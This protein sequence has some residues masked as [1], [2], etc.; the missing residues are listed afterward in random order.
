M[1]REDRN[2]YV[3]IAK[4]DSLFKD[5]N[6]PLISLDPRRLNGGYWIEETTR[7]NRTKYHQSRKLMFSN[8]KLERANKIITSSIRTDAIAEKSRLIDCW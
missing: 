8:S 4:N 2:K 5:I 6:K 7:K 1:V 3:M